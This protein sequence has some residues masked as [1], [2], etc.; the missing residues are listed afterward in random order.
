MPN[1]DKLELRLKGPNVTP[2]YWREPLLTKA[3]F[4]EEGFYKIGDAVRF[5]DPDDVNRGFVFDGRVSEDFKLSTGTWVNMAGVRTSVIAACAP[6][7]RDVVLTGL[8]RNFIGAMIFPDLEVCARHADLPLDSH[9]EV[10]AGHPKVKQTFEEAMKLLATHAT[11]SSNHVARAV[12]L[13]MPPDIDKGEVT[14]KGSINQRAVH[15]ARG[16]PGRGA[17]C[18]YA[19]SRHFRSAASKGLT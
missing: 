2:G 8:D 9:P 12:L 15:S 13:A 17:L 18:R 7:I 16:R 10:I 5:A 4:D 1:I 14:D 6:F 19:R 11:G 3:A